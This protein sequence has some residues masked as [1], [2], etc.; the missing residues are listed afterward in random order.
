MFIFARKKY[1]INKF[2]WINKT[3]MNSASLQKRFDYFSFTLNDEY[4]IKKIISTFHF[5]LMSAKVSPAF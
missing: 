2:V 4:I 5:K 1:S 3:W